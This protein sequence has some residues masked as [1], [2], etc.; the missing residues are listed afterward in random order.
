MK[1]GCSFVLC[2]AVGHVR[3]GA[4]RSSDLEYK[5]SHESGICCWML[6]H[7]FGSMVFM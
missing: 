2:V 4:G 5:Q 6:L 1:R 3:D 7:R